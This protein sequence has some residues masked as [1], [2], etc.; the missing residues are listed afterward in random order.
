MDKIVFFGVGGHAR[1]LWKQI[2]QSPFFQDE[3]IA[4]SD[5][6]SKLWGKEFESINIIPPA[7]LV[8]I[9]ADAFVI[10]STYE[11][12]IERQL[13]VELGISEEKI[14]SFSDYRK[15][16]FARWQY[17]KK[18]KNIESDGSE[19]L[20]FNTEHIVVYTAITG[21]YDTLKEPPFTD[22]KT[23]YVCFT[24]NRDLKSDKWNIEYIWD[25]RLD[26]MHLAKKVKLFP[27]LYFK[28]F[29]TSVWVDAN[30]NIRNDLKSY[31]RK[32]GK[33]KPIL[34]FPHSTRECIYDEAGTCLHLKK[35]VKEKV[36]KQI[37]DYYQMG[38]PLNNGLYEMGCI[39]RRH[40]DMTIQ[41]IMN[42][43]AKEIEKYSY[44]DQLSF[45]VVC[46]KNGFLPDICDL[47]LGRNDWIRFSEH[48]Y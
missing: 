34:C 12:E 13:K 10:L 9:D 42:D 23:T 41:K 38:Y 30:F 4:F 8:Q 44:R 21:N 46:W 27:N 17:D 16:C 47:D 25:D 22:E 39:V 15:K 48:K 26:A 33:N 45:P 11:K 18:Y 31:I 6:N 5:N 20:G 3:Y 28:E 7:D 29:E 19:T 32:Y 43:W 40:N 36:L 2:I 35:G 24:D 1:Y 37:F 14:Y